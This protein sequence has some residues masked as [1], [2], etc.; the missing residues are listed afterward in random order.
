MA[1]KRRRGS[2]NGGRRGQSRAQRQVGRKDGPPRRGGGPGYLTVCDPGHRVGAC[3]LRE[4]EALDKALAELWNLA[5]KDAELKAILETVRRSVPRAE[6]E[7]RDGRAA[8]R[9]TVPARRAEQ[10]L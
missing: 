4:R 6:T 10:S 7:M 3:K 2:S 9:A 8:L 5:E 1:R